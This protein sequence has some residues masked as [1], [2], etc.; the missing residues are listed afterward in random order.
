M[1]SLATPLPETAVAHSA[2]ARSTGRR[3][4]DEAVS[5]L[6][7]NATRFA[8]LGLE[9]RIE[10]AGALLTG[11]LAI[12]EDS[13]HAA[14]AAKGIPLGTPLE[15]EEWTL[16]PWMV[17][18]HLRLVRQSLLA[19]QHNGNTQVGKVG[20]TVDGRLTTQVFPAGP[21][22]GMLFNGVRVD[23]HLQ[24]GITEDEF[25]ASRARFYKGS[26]HGGA[27]VLVLGA[28][29]VNAIPSHDM[30][31]KLF[32]EG[33]VCII[34]MNPVNAYLGPFLEVAF[35]AA[36]AEGFVQ[37]VYGGAEEGAYLVEHSGVDEIHITGSDRTYD[38]IVW[39]PPG[40]EREARKARGDPL[41]T[42]PVTAELGNVSPVLVVPG[43]YS[44]K[45]LRY[46]GADIASAVTYNASFNCNAAK[47][48]VTGRGWAQR[49]EF[50][51]ALEQGLS[52]APLRQ[53]YY[54]G[55]TERWQ[56]LAGERRH[57]Q[58]IGVPGANELPWTL[59]PGLDPEDRNEP[60]FSTEAFCGIVGETQLASADPVEFLERAV[61]FVNERLWGTLSAGIVVDPKLL[62]DPSIAE[63]LEQ[64]IVRLRY[65]AVTVNAW[66]G[67]VF[68]FGTPPWGAHP[69]S[70]P[71]DIQSGTGWVHNTPMIEGIEKAVLRH[72]LVTTP[73]PSYQS[74]HRTA[75]TLMRRMTY[76]EEQ[77]SWSRVPGV[78]AAAMR[79]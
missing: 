54:P 8:R 15:G 16:G 46:Q 21:I 31:T 76:L 38:Q 68:A 72:P 27:V 48:I 63:A 52:D 25:H 51:H 77:A 6:R 42:K 74:G 64:A 28:G 56:R 71:A 23:V 60:L 66:S 12:A 45:A 44:A 35:R 5:R 37:I 17:V 70:S 67:Y 78:L 11:Y 59:L 47:M 75:N 34:K 29:N 22:D 79:A 30:I 61:S 18:R 41:V 50:L 32:N 7:E 2:G 69:S 3:E 58:T 49:A 73:R 13:V 43:S 57:A 40:P 65:G 20:R 26:G 36:I 14:C 55:A 10:L 39:G 1:P 33:K 24:K 9:Q 53:A 62:K 4:L 19:L